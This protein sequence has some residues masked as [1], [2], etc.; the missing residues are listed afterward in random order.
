MTTPLLIYT[1]GAC[2]GN[3]GIGGWGVLMCYGEYRKTLNGAEAMTTNNRMELTAAIEALRAVKRAC[4][5]VLTTDSSYV[6]N[7]ITQGLAGWKRNGWK[8]A[9][10]KA[11]KNVDLWQA[12]D[13]LVA[14]HQI[15]WQWI[16]GHNG[17][18]GN[19]MADQLANEAIA[20]LRAKG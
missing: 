7:G 19:E 2:K 11:V 3:P 9:D 10:K 5:I 16:K 18:P 14:Q 20:E 15:E 6:K 13:A 12:L 17:H 8:T 4:P 1:D